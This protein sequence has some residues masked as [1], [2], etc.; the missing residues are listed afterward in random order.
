MRNSILILLLVCAEE[1]VMANGETARNTAG[2]QEQDTDD[3][4]LNCSDP[5]QGPSVFQG[6]SSIACRAMM[7]GGAHAG[8]IQVFS[9]G[10]FCHIA[11]GGGGRWRGE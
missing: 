8:H 4:Y 9:L 1:S 7:E 5:D 11:I 3:S 6:R 10:V 2:E